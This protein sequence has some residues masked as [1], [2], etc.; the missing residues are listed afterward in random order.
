MKKLYPSYDGQDK[1]I[2]NTEA[3]PLTP[4]ATTVETGIKMEVQKGEKILLHMDPAR[5]EAA[6]SVHLT[7][8]RKGGVNNTL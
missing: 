3:T 6:E 4:M 1:T 7:P 8:E 5:G 2:S